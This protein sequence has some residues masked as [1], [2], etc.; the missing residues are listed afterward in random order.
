M[1]I[2]KRDNTNIVNNNNDRDHLLSLLI[3]LALIQVLL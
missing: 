1:L 3:Y 2:H